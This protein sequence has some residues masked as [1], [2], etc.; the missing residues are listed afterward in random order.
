MTAETD[1][2]VVASFA[3][4]AGDV[5]YMES[6]LAEIP[7]GRQTFQSMESIEDTEEII[8]VA[9]MLRLRQL[10]QK[11]DEFNRA[12]EDLGIS[13][14][15]LSDKPTVIATAHLRGTVWR[16]GVR[17]ISLQGYLTSLDW[18]ADFF[19][20]VGALSQPI[21][22]ADITA[23]DLLEPEIAGEPVK[24]IGGSW[25]IHGNPFIQVEVTDMGLIAAD[26][27]WTE[28]MPPQEF[29]RIRRAFEALLQSLDVPADTVQ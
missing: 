12:A 8:R 20:R 13:G 28:P 4:W 26:A 3:L 1:R 17:E 21:T 11:R 7:R 16:T 10:R 15:S 14:V 2:F 9:A 5:G 19:E 22:D 6:L 25:A 23:G 24:T 27:L 29:D 18:E